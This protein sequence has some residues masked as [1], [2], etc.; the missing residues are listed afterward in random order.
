MAA[1]PRRITNHH[2]LHLAS[3]V[4]G[5][6]G[7]EHTRLSDI[8]AVSGLAPATLLQRFGSLDGLLDAVSAAFLEQVL[9]AFAVPAASPIRALEASLTSIAAARHTIFLAARPAGAA[10]YSLELRKQIAFSLVGAVEAGELMHCDVAMLARRIQIEFYGMTTA[11]LLEGATVD[12]VAAAGL[13]RDV[14]G[15][16]M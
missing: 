11:A 10:T 4:V 3:H 7:A 8:A 16:L 2:L 5:E 12:H 13:V 6:R 14:L 9:D 1:R 15:D